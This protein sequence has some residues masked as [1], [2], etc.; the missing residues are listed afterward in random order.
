MRED[1]LERCANKIIATFYEMQAGDCS[2][3]IAKKQKGYY[4]T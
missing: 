2:I 3:R 4:S 1:V